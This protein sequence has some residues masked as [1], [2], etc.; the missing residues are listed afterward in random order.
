HNRRARGRPFARDGPPRKRPRDR[1][2]TS[3]WLGPDGR[4]LPWRKRP[5]PYLITPNP[6]AH[7]NLTAFCEELTDLLD[8]KHAAQY[9][10]ALLAASAHWRDWIRPLD[11]WLPPVGDA[12]QQFRDLIPHL[13]A[14]YDVP[15]FL[16]VA[17]LPGLT[18]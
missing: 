1:P 11:C 5:C 14:G 6:Q 9:R 7:C 15:H 8:R 4:D 12:Q 3:G 13:L 10:P 17:P 16:D 18:P 2:M